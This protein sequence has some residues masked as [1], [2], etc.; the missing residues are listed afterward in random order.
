MWEKDWD[1]VVS[2]NSNEYIMIQSVDTVT[3]VCICVCALNMGD[4]ERWSLKGKLWQIM[5]ELVRPC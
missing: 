2:K 1:E 3:N 4:S 5:K